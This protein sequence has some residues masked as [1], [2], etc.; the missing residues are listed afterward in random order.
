MRRDRPAHP[1]TRQVD[2]FALTSIEQ[3]L[4]S[5]AENVRTLAEPKRLFFGYLLDVREAADLIGISV[6]TVENLIA[7]RKLHPIR[8]N[9]RIRF[10]REQIEA[11]A[12][13]VGGR[14]S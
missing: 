5:V 3:I 1:P 8:V 9:G 14:R 10:R 12:K 6:R 4:S 11:F 13:R 2:R 7:D